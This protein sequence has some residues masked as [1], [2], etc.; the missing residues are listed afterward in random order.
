MR[1]IEDDFQG[2]VSGSEKSLEVIFH[3]YFKSLVVFSM[4]FGLEQ[5]EAE[6]VVIE[7][8]HRIWEIRSDIKS[9]SA[10]NTLLY[11]SVRN[12][13]INTVRNIK[14]RESLLE[15]QNLESDEYFHDAI[16]EEE[17]TRILFEAIETLPKQC[18]RVVTLMMGGST[19]GE[20]AEQLNLSVSSV[21]TYKS[22]SIEMLKVSLADYPLLLFYLLLKLSEF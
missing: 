9:S 17:V 8:I 13:S 10:L 3:Q 11:T 22:R 7:V 16:V 15:M 19:T 4:R 6:D 14:N 18:K 1:I 21:K 12:R 2:F 20:I 5:M